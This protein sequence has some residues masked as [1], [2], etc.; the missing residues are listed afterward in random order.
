MELIFIKISGKFVR[1]NDT[2]SNETFEK[3]SILTAQ[4]NPFNYLTGVKAKKGENFN[5]PSMICRTYPS[6][7]YRSYGAGRN[8]FSILRI[9]I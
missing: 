7:I 8:T 5:R 1:D 6:T 2:L 3:C 4:L 9:K